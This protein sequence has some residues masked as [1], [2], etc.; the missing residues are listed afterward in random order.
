MNFLG[1]NNRILPQK[2]YFYRIFNP[3]IKTTKPS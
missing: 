2:A 1:G 3:E